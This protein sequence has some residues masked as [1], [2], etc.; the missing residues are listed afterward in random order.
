MAKFIYCS[1]CGLKSTVTRKAIPGY[2]RIIDLIDPHE[3][4]EEPTELDLTPTEVPTNP[5]ID[6]KFV[7]NL[8]G[9]ERPSAV[10]TFD[11]RDRRQE[12]E[13][14]TTAPISVLEQV[15]H[16]TGSHPEGDISK[17]PGDD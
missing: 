2:G 7:E 10:S 5:D 12:S 13:V 1:Q 15:K 3:C 9:L 14:K 4:L 8:N 17:D 6:R 16:A 11:L